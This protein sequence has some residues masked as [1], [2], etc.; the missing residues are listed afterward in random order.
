M[1][2]RSYTFNSNEPQG[3]RLKELTRPNS[4]PVKDDESFTV[5]LSNYMLGNSPYKHNKL[6]N[7]VTMNDAV[8]IVDA[9]FDAV[10]K[11]GSKCINPAKDGRLKN[12]AEA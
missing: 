10:K 5:A 8:P 7:M 1:L 4:K 9:L 3:K 11:A 2:F 6:Y 12:A